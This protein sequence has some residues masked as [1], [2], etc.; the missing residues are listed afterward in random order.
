MY[1]QRMKELRGKLNLSQYQIAEKLGYSQSRYSK[2]EIEERKP[3]FQT[4][5]EIANFFNV[6]VDYLLGY[7]IEINK[8]IIANEEETAYIPI[9]LLGFGSCG[10]GY[11]N[12][13][14]KEELFAIPKSWII[15]NG[16]DYFLS[17]ASGDSMIDDNIV[18]NSLLLF[19]AQS[20]IELDTIGCFYYN[21][22][23]Y[24]KKFTKINDTIVLKSSNSKYDPIIVTEDDDFRVIGKLVKVI[25]SK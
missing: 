10:E 2:Y 17:Y 15:G 5:I 19:K 12:D 20:E 9:K 23:N 25:I 11:N 1:G 21:G 13:Q 14:F 4:L 6:T 16:D 22:E 18:N 24:V 3:D 8:S 7:E